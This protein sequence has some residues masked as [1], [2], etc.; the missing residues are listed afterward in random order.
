M[1][2]DDV[3]KLQNEMLAE[4]KKGKISFSI[5]FVNLIPTEKSDIIDALQYLEDKGIVSTK[6]ASGFWDFKLTAYG[7]DVME[8]M[9]KE[10]DGVSIY[11]FE[12][13]M[14]K[15]SVS[16]NGKH[17]GDFRV[18]YNSDDE[19]IDFPPNDFK[20]EIGDVVSLCGETHTITKVTEERPFNDQLFSYIASFKKHS[21]LKSNTVFNIHNAPNSIIGTQHQAIVYNAVN[22]ADIRK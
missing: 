19:K 4:Y 13:M 15:A 9:K 8:R 3:E 7:I 18:L 10:M 21:D 2:K 12:P 17:I 16:R 11:D 20:P 1:I 6:K 5:S 14:N 22:A